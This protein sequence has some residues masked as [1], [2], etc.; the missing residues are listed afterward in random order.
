MSLP[1]K[2]WMEDNAYLFRYAGEMGCMR[3]NADDILLVGDA[4][5]FLAPLFH[6]IFPK[7]GIQASADDSVIEEVR[8]EYPCLAHSSQV[9]ED[10]HFD[11]IAAP[12]VPSF[13]ESRDFVSFLFSVHSALRIGGNLYLSFIESDKPYQPASD[14]PLWW[15][16]S[17]TATIKK[18]RSEDV[19]QAMSLVG[20]D[21]KAIEKDTVDGSC[22]VVSIHAISR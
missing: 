8:E 16:E 10:N 4:A 21:I 6:Q 9:S 19:L 20:F 18:Y 2:E 17:C 22:D 5:A 15:D 13:L 3:E 1:L 11:I 7:A 14:M 12:F